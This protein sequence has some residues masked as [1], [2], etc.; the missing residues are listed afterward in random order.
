MQRF[1]ILPS[2]AFTVASGLSPFNLSHSRSSS[3]SH[4]DSTTCETRTEKD[5]RTDKPISPSEGHI[6]QD[7][8]FHLFKRAP[9]AETKLLNKALTSAAANRIDPFREKVRFKSCLSDAQLKSLFYADGSTAPA[10]AE[11]TL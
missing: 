2:S 4:R 7:V 5:E 3:S 6:V 8:I 1:L 9:G 10:H 11:A